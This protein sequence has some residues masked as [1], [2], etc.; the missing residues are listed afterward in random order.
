[1]DY[2]EMSWMN[3]QKWPGRQVAEK[4][5]QAIAEEEGDCL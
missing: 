4:Q 3:G 1:M 2:A 5:L